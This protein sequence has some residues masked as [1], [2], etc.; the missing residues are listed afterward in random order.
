MTSMLYHTV[1]RYLVTKLRGSSGSN[2]AWPFLFNIS[3]Y[4]CSALNSI[5]FLLY[6]IPIMEMVSAKGRDCSTCKTFQS[7]S[8]VQQMGWT[9]LQRKSE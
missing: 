6:S 7:V 3:S 8:V 2:P 9:K 1:M 5:I 4:E